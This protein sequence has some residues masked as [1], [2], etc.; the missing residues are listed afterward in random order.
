M[1]GILTVAK[2]I[3][4]R[5]R[6]MSGMGIDELKLHKLLYLCQRENL[7]ITGEAM[8]PET[9][10]GWKYGPVSRVVRD[11]F[12]GETIPSSRATEI[13]YEAQYIVNN[14]MQQYAGYE[15][16]KLSDMTHKEFSWKEARKGIAT[17]ENGNREIKIE[18]I[19]IDAQK[20]RPYD[21]IYD[22]YYDEFDDAEMTV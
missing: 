12:T 1:D 20:V 17:E 16:W 11:A 13:S 14:V 19:L 6:Q 3:C 2:Y 5:Y 7:A 21:T 10:E 9:F 22:M 18:D 8:F 15:S 4:E